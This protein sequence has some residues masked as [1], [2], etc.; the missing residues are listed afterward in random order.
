MKSKITT[1]CLLLS[2]NFVT[3][4][5]ADTQTTTGDCSPVIYTQGKVELNINCHNSQG[6]TP[7]DLK[8]IEGIVSTLIKKND[9]AQDKQLQNQGE[10][11]KALANAVAVL[12]E[13]S[14]TNQ[15][16]SDSER[17]AALKAL[18]Q[19]DTSQAKLL[20]A[21]AA[22]KDEQSATQANKQAAA[23]Y[24]NLGALAFLDNTQEALHAYRRATELD[25]DNA[26]SWN[27]LGHLLKRIGNL[28]EAITAYQNVLNLGKLHKNIEEQAKAHGNLGLVYQVRGELD[29]AIEMQKKALQ[30]HTDLGLK[31]G[32][33]INFGNLGV[34]YKLK[35]NWNEA[36][37]MQKKALKIHKELNNE[38]GI[39]ANYTNLGLL[40]EK[41]DDFN[42]AYD[43]QNLALHLYEKLKNKEGMAANYTNLGLLYSKRNNLT[44]NISMQKKALE[45]YEN[46]DNKEGMAIACGNLGFAYKEKGDKST[47]IDYYKKSLSLYESLSS[48]SVEMIKGQ[49]AEL[50]K[51][52][53]RSLNVSSQ[54][55]DMD[56]STSRIGGFDDSSIGVRSSSNWA[57]TI[58]TIEKPMTITNP[59]KREDNCQGKLNY[60][61]SEN[62]I[63]NSVNATQKKG[64]DNN[65]M[66]SSVYDKSQSPC[67]NLG[68]TVTNEKLK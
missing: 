26:D 52:N 47:A 13:K 48:P 32:I 4:A 20:F 21:K 28:D 30:L 50:E 27:E 7:K 9:H 68:N 11:I 49:L 35:N 36:I 63:G 8:R 17:D 60:V 53:S 31:K 51:D 10:Q 18:E 41:T 61:G 46:Q 5:N 56:V 43:M 39:A 34:L 55:L 65:V 58:M 66:G 57:G 3:C 54:G 23:N 6:L 29:K 22:Q 16:G 12:T 25:P 2:L 1:V 45:I 59:V 24:R 40:Y 42:K 62:G 44:E 15:V 33:A 38:S 64:I 67:V 14:Q 19:G 37:E